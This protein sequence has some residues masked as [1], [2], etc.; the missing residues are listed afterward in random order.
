MPRHTGRHVGLRPQTT[1]ASPRFDCPC[2]VNTVTGHRIFCTRCW[3][4]LNGAPGG[5]RDRLVVP[6][7]ENARTYASAAYR[8]DV[9]AAKRFLTAKREAAAQ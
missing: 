5:L 1:I 3:G 9:E 4:W 6:P 8:A 2:G 7:G